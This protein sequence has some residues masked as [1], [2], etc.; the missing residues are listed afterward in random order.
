M[1]ALAS[2][3]PLNTHAHAVPTVSKLNVPYAGAVHAYQIEWRSG[4]DCRSPGS[5]VASTREPKTVP[6]APLIASAAAYESF[7]GGAACASDGRAS[8]A[9]TAASMAN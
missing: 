8:T 2:A 3:S 7:G 1:S 5:V 4:I 9:A 6:L